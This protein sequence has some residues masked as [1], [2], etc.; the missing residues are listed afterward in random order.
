MI[1]TK[2]I[3]A[4]TTSGLSR[5]PW[6]SSCDWSQL[7][8]R[9]GIGIQAREQIPRPFTEW[10]AQIRGVVLRIPDCRTDLPRSHSLSRER[11]QQV[12]R[13]PVGISGVKPPVIV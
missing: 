13:W 4:L 11:A 5:C 9:R 8:D 12:Y 1:K 3:I 7:P 10:K 6:L 2:L